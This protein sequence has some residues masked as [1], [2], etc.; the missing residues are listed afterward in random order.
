MCSAHRDTYTD[1]HR[2]MYIHIQTDER[3]NTAHPH[4]TLYCIT[5]YEKFR[6]LI[7]LGQAR[8]NTCMHVADFNIYN[9][10]LTIQIL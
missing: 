6:K 4:N 9:V 10:L 1:T 2:D 8:L 7:V 5:L 3:T